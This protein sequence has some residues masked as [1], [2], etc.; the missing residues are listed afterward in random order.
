MLFAGFAKLRIVVTTTPPGSISAPCPNPTN[1]T[2]TA[3]VPDPGL[4]RDTR[5]SVLIFAI[6]FTGLLFTA[7]PNHLL[8]VQE[9]PTVQDPLTVQKGVV[10]KNPIPNTQSLDVPFTTPQAALDAIQL[11]PGFK[12]N[13]YA[14][15]PDVHQ[16]IAMTM[17][18]RGR[19]WVAE[20]FTYSDRSQNYD[21]ELNDRIL[22]FEDKDND[23]RFDDRKVFW[24][25]G[26]KLTGIEIGFGGVWVTCAPTFMFIPDADKDDIPDGPP[27]VLL[28]GFE[29]D[30]IRH[31][32]VNGLRWGPDG[33]LYGRHGIQAT[34]FVGPPGATESQ[35]VPMNCAIW[36]YHPTAHQFEIVAQGGTNPWGFDYDEHGEMFMINTVIGHLFHV[37]PGAVSPYVWFSLQFTHLPGHRANSRPF[38]LG[39]YRRTLG[40]DQG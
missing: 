20:C 13:L 27:Q 17:D 25:G 21:T 35:R 26:K 14:S 38:S 3:E 9:P 2:A 5:I 39:R 28:D 11:P 12:A 33:W 34:S 22:I 24:E 23:G 7:C 4:K 32:I 10:D 19:L 29:D 31:N 36:R 6:M 37:V 30:V 18:E 16:P 1:L 15:E 8:A 40:G